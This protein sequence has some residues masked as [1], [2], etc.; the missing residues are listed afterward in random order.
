MSEFLELASRCDK[1]TL[2]KI[3]DNHFEALKVLYPEEYNE[4]IRRIKANI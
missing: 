2:L 1:E 3:L 4:L